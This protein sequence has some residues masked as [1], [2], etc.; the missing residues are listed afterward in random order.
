MTVQI[1]KQYRNDILK[2]LI[3]ETDHRK[4]TQSLI[5]KEFLE[6]IIIFFKKVVKAKLESNTITQDWYKSTMLSSQLNKED[7]AWNAGLNLKSIGNIHGSQSKDIVINASTK[8]YDELLLHINNLLTNDM[9]INLTITLKSVSVSLSLNESLVVINAIAVM[10]AG[11]RG[12]MWSAMGKQI[13]GPLV[14]LLC[15][16][17]QVSSKYYENN[18][19]DDQN[20]PRESDFFLTNNKGDCLRCEVKLM[21]KGNP[22]SADGAMARNVKIFIADKLSKQNKNELDKRNIFWI[23]MADGNTLQQFSDCLD[24]INIPHHKWDA[25][26]NISKVILKF[27]DELD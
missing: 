20:N 10:R 23:A 4:I 21:G 25:K 26:N 16:M 13:E 7:I 3:L 2:N 8:H 22:E 5:D 11:I 14:I 12:G 1:T 27:L 19:I 18:C 9:N 24:K 17:L 15:K 6:R